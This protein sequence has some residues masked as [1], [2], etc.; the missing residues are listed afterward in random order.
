VLLSSQSLIRLETTPVTLARPLPTHQ[1]LLT[2]CMPS[3][4][5]MSMCVRF[6]LHTS[7]ILPSVSNAIRSRW[8]AG[9]RISYEG[10]SL[11]RSQVRIRLRARMIFSCFVCVCI[12]RVYSC[13]CVKLPLVQSSPTARVCFFV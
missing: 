3:A 2:R 9:L 11:L 7:Y 8:P 13:L 4:I 5:P 6:F 1:T 12:V 10:Y